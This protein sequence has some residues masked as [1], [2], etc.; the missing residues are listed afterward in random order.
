MMFWK[1][2]FVEE[3]VTKK[4]TFKLPITKDVN[5]KNANGTWPI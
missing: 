3:V 4:E 2:L 5:M 1:I